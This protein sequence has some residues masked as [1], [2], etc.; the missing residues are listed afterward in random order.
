MSPLPGVEY[1]SFDGRRLPATRGE[2]VGSEPVADGWRAWDP[3]R[4]K[5]AAMMDR[6]LDLGVTPEGTILYLGAAAGTSVSHVAD[7]AGPT[8]AVEFAPRPM[9]DLVAVAEARP[10]LFPLLKDARQPATYAHVVE[11]DI[12]VLIQDVATR[13]QAAVA[14]RNRPFLD[15]DGRL[16]M[17]VKARSEDVTADPDTVFDRVLADLD[18]SYE[19]I[20]TA[21][22]DP[23]HADHLAVIA[24]PR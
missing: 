3:R 11:S 24:T 23:H 2:P 16:V 15:A 20:E 5:V 1:R 21:R 8:Y 18:T 19:V 14:K 10:T 4:S 22:L 17:A 13:G 7:I 12:D 6:D 9:R